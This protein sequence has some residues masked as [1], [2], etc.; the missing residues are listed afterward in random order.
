MH[1][2]ALFAASWLLPTLPLAWH[3]SAATHRCA[4][5][6][7]T[8]DPP[9]QLPEPSG[10][11]PNFFAAYDTDEL[12]DLLNVHEQLFGL[13]EDL[14][15]EGKEE[16]INEGNILGG[17]HDAVLRTIA[18]AEAAERDAAEAAD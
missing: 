7:A 5:V 9:P 1:L 18:E 10:K 14:E 13:N 3:A 16:E 12:V 15:P 11:E 6:R 8:A 4:G 17:L 2:T